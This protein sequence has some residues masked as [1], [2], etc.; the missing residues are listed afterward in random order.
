[1]FRHFQG[2]IDLNPQISNGALQLRMAEQQLNRPEVLRPTDVLI[3]NY[4]VGSLAK[5]GLDYQT[6][7]ELNPRLVYCSV[8]GFGQTGPR[9]PSPVTTSSFKA[10]AA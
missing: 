2:I 7:S 1:L 4:K 3:E 9:A 5:Y 6:L 10:W 8:T